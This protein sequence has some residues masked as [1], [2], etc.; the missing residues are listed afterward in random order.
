MLAS[1]LK[2]LAN[3]GGEAVLDKNDKSDIKRMVCLIGGHVLL[4]LGFVG[5]VLPVMPTTVFWIGAAACY[6]RS[7]PERFRR[8]VGRGR[9]GRVIK[10]FLDH[11]VISQH[12][13]WAASLGMLF[14]AV[15]LLLLP[16]GVPPTV[17]GLLGLGIG[18]GYVVSRPSKV[19]HVAHLALDRMP[20]SR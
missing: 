20:V 17:I 12:G 13:K 1:K 11:G 16:L 2:T 19:P 8:L 6:S 14:S 9:T 15:L 18:A 3:L 5:M 7:S 10:D 4:G